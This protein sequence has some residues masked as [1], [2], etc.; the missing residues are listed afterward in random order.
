MSETEKI[1]VAV[2]KDNERLYPSGNEKFIFGYVDEVN[3]TVATEVS[4]FI[5]TRQELI[6]LV[7]YW[8]DEVI[9][10]NWFMYIYQQTGRDWLN[11]ESFA[12]CRIE[13]IGRLLGDD[14]VKKAIDE[15]KAKLCKVCKRMDIFLN[16]SEVEREAL[17]EECQ[18]ELEERNSQTNRRR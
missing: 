4:G 17:R 11:Q 13:R 14:E 2:K 1:V 3:G 15:L 6:Q 16:G 18:K 8:A 7:K 10:L 12:K 9:E 5:P